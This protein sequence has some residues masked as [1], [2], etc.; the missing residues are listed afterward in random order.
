MKKRILGIILTVAVVSAMSVGCGQKQ[1][2]TTQTETTEVVES[3]TTT[4]TETIEME[5]T[6]TV[7]NTEMTDVAG[8]EMEEPT[9]IEEQSP[10]SFTDMS[11]IMYA[12]KAVN[13]RDLPDTDGNKVGGLSINDEVTVTGQCNETGWYRI[14]CNGVTA[15]VSNSYLGDSK[16]ETTENA[17]SNSS[18]QSSTGTSS[19]NNKSQS[20]TSDSGSS[21]TGS[22]A[23]EELPSN[24]Y[25]L[26]TVVQ[27]TGSSVSFYCLETF[28]NGVSDGYPK[29]FYDTAHQATEY[30]MNMGKTPGDEVCNGTV[31]EYKEGI[32]W[33]WTCYYN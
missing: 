4:G 12:Q 32:V 28:T 17:S 1:I 10:Y 24:P 3:V 2:D 15:Y 13:V 8:T 31:G 25:T 19:T 20:T 9:E 6:E 26:N 16:V 18:S 27:D 29:N 23:S 14:D 7:E 5:S 33:K 21:N 30:I 22:T 11:A